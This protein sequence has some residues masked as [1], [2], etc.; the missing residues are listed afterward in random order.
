MTEAD[1]VLLARQLRY[2]RARAAEYDATSYGVET[3]ARDAIPALVDAMGIDGDVLEIAGGTGIWTR[4]L[5]RVADTVHYLDG[6]PEMAALARERVTASN[7]S[8]EVADA[9]SYRPQRRYDVVFFA[10]WISHVPS[11]KFE[12][13]WSVV[14]AALAPGGRVLCLDELPARAVNEDEIDGSLATR[15]LNDGS[16]YRIVKVFYDP[17]DL[18]ARLHH[19]G[20]DATVTPTVHD[21]FVATA[22][23]SQRQG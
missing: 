13:F 19:I 4:E 3:G 14:D 17:A 12:E 9:F 8:F 11:T 5:A 10:A 16:R 23:R 21:W 1:H 20:W 2:Y 6:A 15:M 18:V 22:V 7:V